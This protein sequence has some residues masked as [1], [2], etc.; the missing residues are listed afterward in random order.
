M[1]NASLVLTVLSKDRPGLVQAIAQMVAD[2][3]ANWVESRMAHLGGQF[4]GILHVEVDAE[5]VGSL[6]HALEHL[7]EHDLKLVIHPGADVATAA[8]KAEV[9]LVHLELVG[10]DRPGIVSEITRVLASAGVNVEEFATE[11]SAAPTTGQLL[12]QATAQL[13]IPSTVSQ[14][15]LREDLEQ[16]AADMMVEISLG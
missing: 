14:T 7:K 4:A 6:T 5:Q 2:H 15:Q 12:F 9:P 10:Q 3:G 11:R 13:R 16:L 1:A 8:A